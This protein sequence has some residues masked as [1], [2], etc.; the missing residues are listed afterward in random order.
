MSVAPLSAVSRHGPRR[1]RINSVNLND[2]LGNKAFERESLLTRVTE[3]KAQI[4]KQKQEIEDK[5]EEIA[6]KIGEVGNKNEEYQK[7]Q[8]ELKDNKSELKQAKEK[9]KQ[10]EAKYKEL[11]REQK[12][13]QKDKDA[14]DEQASKCKTDFAE[15]VSFLETQ[16]EDIEKLLADK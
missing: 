15:A 13:L 3:I 5:K 16:I 4:L 10:E 1:N 14:V 8:N 11:Q 12:Q 9:L 6:E 2:F 7:L